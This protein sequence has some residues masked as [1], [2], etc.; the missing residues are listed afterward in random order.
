MTTWTRPSH[1]PAVGLN[2][3]S[4]NPRRRHSS[5]RRE[6]RAAGLGRRRAPTTAPFGLT[7]GSLEQ[8]AKLFD[9]IEVTPNSVG[10]TADLHNYRLVEGGRQPG[11][12]ASQKAP[13]RARGPPAEPGSRSMSGARQPLCAF[14]QLHLRWVFVAPVNLDGLEGRLIQI[15]AF[16]SA[17]P[18]LERMTRRRR[19]VLGGQ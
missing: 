15:Q 12:P 4:I 17:R 2:P 13:L 3:S 18:R 7:I 10:D 16:R 5:A 1:A 19:A 9:V 14:R 8:A 11:K 6:D